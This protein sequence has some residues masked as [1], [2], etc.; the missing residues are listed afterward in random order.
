MTRFVRAFVTLTAIGAAA[1]VFAQTGQPMQGM[2]PTGGAE[3]PKPEGAAEKAPKEA[4]LPTLPVLPPYPGQEQKKLDLVTF[5]GYFR[6]RSNWFNKLSLGFEDLGSGLPFPQSLL[7]RR[8]TPAELSNCSQSIGTAN[9]RMRFEPTFHLSETVSIHTQIDAL[10]NLVFGATPRGVFWDGSPRPPDVPT[11]ALT[12]TQV[13]PEAGRNYVTDSIAVKR[14]WGEVV[15]PLGRLRVGRMPSHWGLGM[16]THS[17]GYDPIHGTTCTDCDYGDTVDRVQFGTTIPGTPFRAAVALDWLATGPTSA[18]TELWRSRSGGQPI[19][20]EDEDDGTQW[21]VMISRFDDPREWQKKLDEKAL[22]LNYGIYFAYRSQQFEAIDTTLGQA[23][24]ADVGFVER[25]AKVYTPDVWGRLAIGD[26]RLEAELSLV[27][28]SIKTLEDLVPNLVDQDI[29]AMGG[30][31]K[32]EYLLVGGDLVLGFEAGFATGDQWE[33]GGRLNVHDAD[34]LPQDAFDT[35]ISNFRFNYDYHVDLILFRQLLGTVTN[36][37]YL[38]PTMRYDITD[39]FSL[40]VAVITSFALKPVSLPGNDPFYGLELNGDVG[41]HNDDEG[42]FAGLS[43]GV[44]FPFSGLNRPSALFPI[45]NANGIT[46]A[47]DAKTAQTIQFRT[48]FKY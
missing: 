41:Y 18:Q 43:Y 14:A 29:F 20:L 13:P 24:A 48:V 44:L 34:Y 35:T 37:V 1:P 47:G 21:T 2:P 46:E 12:N 30:V 23:P 17:G 26:L 33:D 39:R 3:E 28:G 25:G 9:I 6:F 15:T 40:K 11:S 5:D 27:F 42:F 8:D 45:T 10:D 19:D 4:T 32:L 7:C 31:A 16:L 38:K 22:A 36:A